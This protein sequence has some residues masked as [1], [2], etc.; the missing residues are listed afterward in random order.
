MMMPVPG[1]GGGYADGPGWAQLRRAA[2]AGGA[3]TSAGLLQYEASVPFC[4]SGGLAELIALNILPIGI[5]RL[6]IKA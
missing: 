2:L 3:S 4:F 6:P 5:A 1:A